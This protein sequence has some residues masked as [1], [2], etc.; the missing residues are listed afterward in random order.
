MLPG[1]EDPD[2]A[3]DPTRQCP[4]APGLQPSLCTPEAH[5]YVSRYHH[6][7]LVTIF[8]GPSKHFLGACVHLMGYG[9]G[10]VDDSESS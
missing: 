9:E 6:P 1:P 4:R 2:K 8:W 7:P 3:Q 5:G 10:Y